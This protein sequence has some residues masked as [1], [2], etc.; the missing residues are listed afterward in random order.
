MT[1]CLRE[2]MICAV[3]TLDHISSR[4]DICRC[5]TMRPLQIEA[6]ERVSIIGRNGTGKVDAAA[7]HQRR[8]WR[9]TA[10]TVWRQPGLRVARLVQ[11]VPLTAT[12]S[13]FDVVAE[14]L[15][16]S[17]G[18]TPRTGGAS[19]RSISSC[20]GSI[21]PPRQ[22]ST[23]CP[24]AGGAACCWHAR[25]SRNPMCCCST[26]RPTISTST[27]SP[28][29]RTFSPTTSGAVVFVTHDRAFLQRLATRIVELD[30][31]RLTSWPGDYAT[32]AQ[33]EGGVAGQRGGA[34]GQ[35]RQAAGRRRKPGC[36]R[37]SRRGGRATKDACVR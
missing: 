22:W 16:A 6:R 26:S 36:G 21:S 25:W 27:P 10:G 4:S 7:D 31:G 8:D 30:R 12:Q 2:Q 1:S 33:E 24:A 28:G 15:V 35:I 3:V 5:W 11:D 18:T 17:R 29:S 19:T 32:F 20:R 14:G 23:P 34:A 37:G 9:L 13:V